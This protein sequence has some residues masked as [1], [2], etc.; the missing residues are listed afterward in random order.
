[1]SKETRLV[2]FSSDYIVRFC[3][4]HR[5]DW[6]LRQE[7][8]YAENW[9]IEPSAMG[10]FFDLLTEKGDLFT[11]YEYC[12]FAMHAPVTAN[13]ME[14]QRLT[15]ELQDC[16][17]RGRLMRNFYPSGIDTLHAWALLVETGQFEQCIID[18]AED[19][20]GKT[21]L[22]LQSK[23]GEM[24]HVALR[25][26]SEYTDSWQSRKAQ[27]GERPADTIEIILPCDERPKGPGNKRWYEIEDFAALLKR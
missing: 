20:V 27:R 1:M 5:I 9:L 7:A 13:G 18:T 22:T 26:G 11:Q 2:Y 3:K 23:S 19:A 6:G 25:V 10:M 12:E 15:V 21:D 8:R 4:E 17:F 16:L 14:W 24:Y